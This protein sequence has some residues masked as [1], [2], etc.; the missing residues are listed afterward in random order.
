MIGR[1]ADHPPSPLRRV[2]LESLTYTASAATSP[3]AGNCSAVDAP[4]SA[5]DSLAAPSPHVERPAIVAPPTPARHQDRISHPHLLLL[6]RAPNAALQSRPEWLVLRDWASTDCATHPV[7][8]LTVVL[9]GSL[10]GARTG[11]R[12]SQDAC[13]YEGQVAPLPKRPSSRSASIVQ[14]G[15]TLLRE[16]SERQTPPT[17]SFLASIPRCTQRG[18]ESALGCQ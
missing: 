18:Q 7:P 12:A 4:H 16:A 3:P 14:D 1:V 15:R 2:R 6:P 13:R 8:V 11:Q 5:P 17:P 10:V 9:P